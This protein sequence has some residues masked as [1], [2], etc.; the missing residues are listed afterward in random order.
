MGCGDRTVGRWLEGDEK[1]VG[2]ES[3]QWEQHEEPSALGMGAVAVVSGEEG[4]SPEGGASTGPASQEL[5][6]R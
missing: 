3:S 5:E 1:L 6:V 4:L 2:T